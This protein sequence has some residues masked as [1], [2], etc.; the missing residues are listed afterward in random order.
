M[1]SILIAEDEPR[2]VAFLEK[3]LRRHGYSTAIALDGQQA[4]SLLH[5]HAFDLV[6]LDWRLPIK[7]GQT[8]LKELR[9]QK[10]HLP[11]IVITAGDRDLSYAA[12]LQQGADDCVLKPFQFSHLLAA[13]GIQLQKAR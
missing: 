4:I 10:S 13:I 9:S 11:V 3:G 2:I 8:V 7:D 1:C 6:L 12:A 5:Q